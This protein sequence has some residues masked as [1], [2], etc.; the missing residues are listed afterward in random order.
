MLER[1]T[2]DFTGAGGGENVS[3]VVPVSFPQLWR[4]G[5]VVLDD[6]TQFFVAALTLQRD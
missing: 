2:F 1:A 4:I 6:M 3:N 5:F